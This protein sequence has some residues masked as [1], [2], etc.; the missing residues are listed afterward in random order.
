[1]TT[2][3]IYTELPLFTDSIYEYTISLE[4]QQRILTFY[5]NERD[6]SWRMDIKQIDGTKIAMGTKLVPEYPMLLNIKNP[7]L[8][9][10]FYLS[11]E[12]EKQEARFL[13]DS[14]VVP[15]FYK[16]FHIYDKETV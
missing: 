11:T 8:L 14:G 9:G 16:L 5:F 10:Y 1:M 3:T 12:N 4:E 15:Q 13:Q 7:N 6:M 2:T